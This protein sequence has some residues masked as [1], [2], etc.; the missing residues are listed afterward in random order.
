MM[1]NRIPI[2]INLKRMK[3]LEEFRSLIIEYFKNIEPISYLKIQENEKALMARTQINYI[4]DEVHQVILLAGVP[5][6]I[7]YSPPPAFGGISGDIDLI[8]NIFNLHEFQIS[9]N[10]L[11]DLV[12]RAI[13]VYERDKIRS[14]FRT[15]NPLYWLLLILEYIMSIPFYIL[16]RVGF[17]QDKLEQSFWGRLI[18]GLFYL[19]TVLAA[20]LTALEKLGYL[21]WFKKLIKGN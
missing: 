8:L 12:D 11:L 13:G 3:L 10:M 2:W 19:I 9:P 6:S 4:I 15:F 16:G 20:F 5:T 18:K 7:F 14:I 17:N 1:F 21:E